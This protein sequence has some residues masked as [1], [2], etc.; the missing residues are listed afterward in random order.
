MFIHSLV[1]RGVSTVCSLIHFIVFHFTWGEGGGGVKGKST[2]FTFCSVYFIFDCFPN[3]LTILNFLVEFQLSLDLD[4]LQKFN[5]EGKIA[6]SRL[7]PPTQ[8]NLHNPE[9]VILL[10]LLFLLLEK[11]Q[12]MKKEKHQK[13]LCKVKPAS[14]KKIKP[15]IPIVHLE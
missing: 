9:S 8:S 4:L 5:L 14:V 7:F 10:F 13:P 15:I 6:N 2:I 12:K 11:M 3:T 1:G